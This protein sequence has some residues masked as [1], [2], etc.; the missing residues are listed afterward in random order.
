M[1]Y[2]LA[3]MRLGF[4]E[5]YSRDAGWFNGDVIDLS[6]AGW[7]EPWGVG[8]ICL[9]AIELKDQPKKELVL[10]KHHD[11]LT[12][13][14]RIHFPQ[15]MD[16]MGYG[17]FLAPLNSLPMVE[18]PNLN[19]HE[20]LH[21][22]YR[23]EFNARLSSNIRLML[24]NFG[25]RGEDE[26]RVT[27]L[28][29]ELGNN[30]FDHNEGV[31]PTNV[32]GAIMVAQNYPEKKFIEIAIADPGIGFLGSLKVRDPNLA[33][34]VDAIQLGLTGVTG[35]VGEKRGNGL[36]LVQDWTINKFN[37]KVRVHSGEGLVVVDEQGQKSSVVNRIL[38]TLAS[39]VIEYK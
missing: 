12:Y 6:K 37:G 36:R 26:Q 29:G 22:T 8:M 4:G 1:A 25:L 24:R 19:L 11:V 35:R 17:A 33:N 13:L 7:C 23:D 30:V 9:R 18:H 32:G 27:S 20:I 38:G 39:V 31:W 10:P 3:I 14:K 15:F 16:A 2:T 21:C 28:I 5:I 34:D